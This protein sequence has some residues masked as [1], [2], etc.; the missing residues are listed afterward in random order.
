[1][2]QKKF[3]HGL[4]EFIRKSP[5]Q[6]HAVSM[7]KERLDNE[8]FVE[9]FE[10]DVW[11][12]DE[13]KGYYVIKNR[14]SIIAFKN[15]KK[16][17]AGTGICIAGSHTDSPCL[18]IKPEPEKKCRSYV[19]LGVEVYGGPLLNPWF[20]R[21]LSIAG[22]VTYQT[23]DKLIRSEIIDF[24]KNVAFISSIPIHLD[25]EANKKRSI[26]QQKDLPPVLMQA[27]EEYV[28]FDEIILKILRKKESAFS[29]QLVLSHEL[30]LYDTQPAC[31][32]GIN[33]EF[34]T[35]P[36]ID[37]LFSCYASLI[38]F[39]ESKG[40]MPCMIVCNDHE[41]IGSV[42]AAGAQGPFLK[43]LLKRLCSDIET[44]AR[45]MSRSLF[46]SVDNAHAFHPN[47][48]DRFDESHSPVINA[49]PV[50]KI[51]AN[52][53]Y[54]TGSEIFAIFE[55]L[56]RENEIPV[57][58][59]VMRSDMPCGSTIGPVTEAETGIKT[60]DIGIPTFAMHS[61]REVM[62]AKDGALMSKALIAFFEKAIALNSEL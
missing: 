1:M 54:A 55:F 20:D 28:S 13:G 46:V 18:R 62:G 57:Q 51:N 7:I 59:F 58:K 44:Y 43:L 56:C 15:I 36:R 8:G 11:D 21:N 14:T 35:G 48:P 12:P 26:N 5:T 29:A 22:K 23:S 50:V 53:R 3:N 10:S 32:S 2:D 38:S 39:L 34:I 41:E 42:S 47:Y 17:I 37:N 45:L 61:I 25:R 6:F 31:Y 27:E 9:L 19:Q 24:E 30:N 40:D 16:N 33:D 52:H 4:M 60:I 49:G